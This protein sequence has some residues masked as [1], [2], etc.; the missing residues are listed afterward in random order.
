LFNKSSFL[1]PA[2]DVTKI[3]KYHQYHF[4]HTLLCC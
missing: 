4:G 2:L 3:Y 1:A